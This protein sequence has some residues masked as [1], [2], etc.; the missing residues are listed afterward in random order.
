MADNDKKVNPGGA[1]EKPKEPESL[2]KYAADNLKNDLTGKLPPVD[3]AEKSAYDKGTKVV[4]I[5][6]NKG[7]EQAAADKKEPEA[8]KKE[9]AAKADPAAKKDE[10]GDK[11]PKDVSP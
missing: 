6:F 9:T 3:G 1:E 11:P 2:L 10:Q 7:K 4:N 8:A 5:T